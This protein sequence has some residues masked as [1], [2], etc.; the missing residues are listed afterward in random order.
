[1]R[2]ATS[3]ASGLFREVLGS[4]Q[5]L[6]FATSFAGLELRSLTDRFAFRHLVGLRSEGRLS[7]ASWVLLTSPRPRWSGLSL[8]GRQLQRPPSRAGTTLHHRWISRVAYAFLCVHADATAP[9]GPQ[10]FD[11]SCLPLLGQETPIPR[12]RPSPASEWVGSRIAVFE[13]CSAFTCV[14]A[15]TLAESL[16]DPLTSECSCN[17]NPSCRSDCYRLER[18]SCRVGLFPTEKRHSSRRT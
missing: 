10:E 12:Q 14:S 18:P 17:K 3:V 16:M 1:M 15:C 9:A 11:R 8:A 4:R 13:A 5:S 7:S 2:A 6:A